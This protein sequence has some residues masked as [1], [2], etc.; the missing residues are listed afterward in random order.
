MNRLSLPID[1]IDTRYDVVVIGSGYGGAI[2]ASRLARTGKRVC[3]LERGKEIH[4]GE[5]PSDFLSINKEFGFQFASRLVDKFEPGSPD[6]FLAN[7]TGM[8]QFHVHKDINVLVG[9]GLGG[10]SLINANVSLRPALNIFEDPSWPSE[11]KPGLD[12]Q[13]PAD[14]VRGFERAERM[15]G[16]NVYPDTQPRLAKMQAHELSA[17]FINAPFVKVP[18]NVTFEDTVNRAGVFQSACTQCGDCVSGCNVGAKNTVLMNYLPDAQQF[19]AEIFCE[20]RVD[21]VARAPSGKGFHVYYQV[22]DAGREKFGSPDLFVE[23]DV[24]VLGAGTLGSTEI[25]LRSKAA[26]LPV[27]D[28]LGLHFG[29]N[30]DMLA[31]S[32]NGDQPIHGVGFGTRKPGELEAVGPTI[33]S[34]IDMRNE[35]AGEHV[36]LDDRMIMEEGAI[37]GALGVILPEALAV[38]AAAVG[39]PTDDSLKSNLRRKVRAVESAVMGVYYGATDHTQTYLVMANDDQSGKMLLDEN[40]EFAIDWPNVGKKPVFELASRRVYQATDALNGVYTKDPLWTRAF[41]KTLIT[42]H[43]LGGCVIGDSADKAVCNHKGQVFAGTSGTDVHEGLYV[44][45]GSTIPC[46]LGVNPLLTISALAE[47]NAEL[48][49]RDRNWTIDWTESTVGILPIDQ[50]KIGIRFTETMHGFFQPGEKESY[51]KGAVEG[52]EHDNRFRFLLTIQTDDLDHMLNSPD[53]ESICVG[54]ITAPPLSPKPMTVK[55]GIFNLIVPDPERPG[56]KNMRYRLPMLAEDG[57]HFY[58]EGVK[59]LHDDAGFDVWSDSTTLFIDVY[60]GDSKEGELIGK[61]ILRL[62]PTDFATQ[63]GTIEVLNAKNAEEKTRALSAFAGRFM[64]SLANIYLHGLTK[65]IQ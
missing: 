6:A 36:H 37:P 50:P 14:L 61:G 58:M 4:P 49:A 62:T 15:L 16:A 57:Q 8:F 44:A 19:G 25:L 13:L 28:C 55:G 27:S 30:G 43:P 10:T 64:G 41:Q 32:Y 31:F 24:V 59:L 7:P 22:L 18:I 40:A 45:D 52:K 5:Y 39:K 1:K 23:A 60:K 21:R 46:A 38:A 51:E 63:L 17:N 26:G 53:H 3:V 2:S 9:Y 56:V 48:L 29:G 34:M 35:C 20:V 47:R 65:L 12:G 11:L 42:V 33:T 54:T